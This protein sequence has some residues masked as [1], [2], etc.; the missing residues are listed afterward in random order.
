VQ[1]QLSAFPVDFS[2]KL[3]VYSS[4]AAFKFNPANGFNIFLRPILTAICE[5]LLYETLPELPEL[6]TDP[7]D[8]ELPT[9]PALPE[10][11]TLGGAKGGFTPPR[12]LLKERRPFR[13]RSVLR[14]VAL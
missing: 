11:P 14:L 8:P 5:G 1:G 2:H 13:L 9:D 6:P 3:R 4:S 10:D 7:A 12:Y